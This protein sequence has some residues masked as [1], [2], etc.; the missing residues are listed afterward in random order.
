MYR[1]LNLD[2]IGRVFG[3]WSIIEFSHKDE[4]QRALYWK[5]KC[6]CEC[7]KIGIVR[8]SQL[9]QGTKQEFLNWV[10]LIYKNIVK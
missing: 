3:K 6:E 1:H 5:C 2:N 8:Y 10:K 7:G 9:T 4:T